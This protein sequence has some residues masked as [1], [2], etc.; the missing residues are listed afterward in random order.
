[1]IAEAAERALYVVMEVC[2][3]WR[4][5]RQREQMGRRGAIALEAA[6]AV[7]WLESQVYVL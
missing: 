1:M 3:L 4:W 2:L 5:W 7:E 6:C